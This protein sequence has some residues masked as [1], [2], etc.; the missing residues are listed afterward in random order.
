MIWSLL[1][2]G[3]WTINQKDI[4]SVLT[5][6]YESCV[7]AGA[8]A[9]P[10]YEDSVEKVRARVEKIFNDVH[11]NPVVL[12]EDP[13]P[14][15]ITFAAVD[16][17]TVKRAVFD[18]LWVPYGTALNTTKALAALEQGNG[19]LLYDNSFT[20]AMQEI[21]FHCSANRSASQR[22]SPYVA[23]LGE[24]QAAIACGDQ[25]NEGTKTLQEFQQEYDVVKQLSQ[26]WA[27]TW[28]PTVPSYCS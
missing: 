21:V 1:F 6:V 14:D 15:N 16:Y 3:N 20:K 27:S 19:T 18:M 23:N 17:S 25:L 8:S 26:E 11:L 24:I 5:D 7:Q 13:R 22:S 28:L 12:Y 9:C 2:T 10:I 4:D